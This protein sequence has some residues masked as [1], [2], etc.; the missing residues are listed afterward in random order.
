MTHGHVTVQHCSVA[1]LTVTRSLFDKDELHVTASRHF[2]EAARSSSYD[3]DNVSRQQQA[4]RGT[5]P[6][7]Y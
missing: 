2:I 5:C 6:L 4:A 1:R 7:R 3:N